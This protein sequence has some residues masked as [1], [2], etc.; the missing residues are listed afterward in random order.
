MTTTYKK[1][2]IAAAMTLAVVSGTAVAA[3]SM[4][5][6][7]YLFTRQGEVWVNSSGEC[8]KVSDWTPEYALKQCDPQYF[9]EAEPHTKKVVERVTLANGSTT[10][11]NSN[12]S[13]LRP[14]GE[15]RLTDVV[16]FIGSFYRVD[17]VTV[18]GYA[19]RIGNDE[20]NRLLSLRRAESVK[21]FLVGHGLDAHLITTK[22]LGETDQ[23]TYCRE[24]NRRDLINCYQP[25][26]RV[27]IEIV[28]EQ[29][30]R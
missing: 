11:F 16:K 23:S 26:R 6:P 9:S 8:W 10:Y 15:V 21:A 22:G 13:V 27:D 2:L 18:R 7:G 5:K 19:D 20:D 29:E 12:G 4:V 3:E 30:T 14:E 1:G 17:Q 28:G 24:M 25:D